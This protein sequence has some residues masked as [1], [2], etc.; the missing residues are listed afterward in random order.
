MSTWL[1]SRV[2][3]VAAADYVNTSLQ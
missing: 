1:H 2:P 3:G